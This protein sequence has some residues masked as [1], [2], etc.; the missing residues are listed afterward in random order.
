LWVV[1]TEPVRDDR[2]SFVRLYCERELERIRPGLR[3]V[4]VNRSVTL[5]RGTVR[6]MHLQRPPGAECKLVRCLRGGVFDVAVDLRPGSPTYL[7]WYGT[8]LTEDNERSVLVP[9]GVAHGFQTLTDDAHM[10]YQHTA[11]WDRNL[12]SG[13]RFDDPRVAIDWPLRVTAVSDRDRS[14]PTAD[15][16]PGGPARC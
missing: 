12:E 1:E 16:L 13:V 2:G 4:Q 6:G 9:E 3:F 10:L 11:F 14:L 5:K 8:E 7:G 15:E